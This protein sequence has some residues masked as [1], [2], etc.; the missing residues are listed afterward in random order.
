MDAEKKT[1]DELVELIYGWGA[2]RGI[3]ENSTPLA[4]YKKTG[5]EYHELVEAATRFDILNMPQ[6]GRMSSQVYADAEDLVDAIG[7]VFVTLCMV[8][9]T[10]GLDIQTCISHA[11]DQ[12]KDRTGYLTPDGTFVKD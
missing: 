1:I 6:R 12:I 3:V 9:A 4:Q 2:D 10:A 7:D 11:Y 5:S 8:A